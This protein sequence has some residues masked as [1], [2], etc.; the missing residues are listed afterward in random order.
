LVKRGVHS[1]TR[2]EVTL[3][4]QD[5]LDPHFVK[6]ANLAGRYHFPDLAHL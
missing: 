3:D 1:A 5:L 6:G 2:P 4:V